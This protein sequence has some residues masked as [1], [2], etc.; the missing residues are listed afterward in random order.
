MPTKKLKGTDYIYESISDDGRLTA[1]QVKIRRKC[2]SDHNTSFDDLE[3]AKAFSAMT[4]STR[5]VAP[6]YP[7]PR[8]TAPA[9]R[10]R[11]RC[12]GRFACSLGG[13]DGSR[14][15]CA[16]GRARRAM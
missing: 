7:M 11:N 3:E 9:I 1:Y 13:I 4:P 6:T 5:S 10:A 12:R 14:C 15:R 8:D 2:F 16:P